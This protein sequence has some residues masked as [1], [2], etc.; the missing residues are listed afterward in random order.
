METEIR[1]VIVLLIAMLGVVGLYLCLFGF[2]K[3]RWK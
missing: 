3:L 2:N 1:I